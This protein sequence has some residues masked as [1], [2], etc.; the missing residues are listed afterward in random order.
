MK[1]EFGLNQ[2][3]R[4]IGLPR[5][6]WYYHQ[7][8]KVDYDQKYWQ[9]KQDLLEITREH[10]S[11]GY[12]RIT[13]ELNEN[14][15][16]HINKKVV[17]KLTRNHELQLIRKV[18]KPKPSFITKTLVALRDKMNIVGLMLAE[19]KTISLFEVCYT[20]FTELIYGCGKRRAQL[21]P[22]IEHVSKI[23]LGWAVGNTP[24]TK[25]AL[26]AWN[27]AAKRTKGLG[28]STE[29]LIAHHDRDPV[30]TG[31]E[32]LDQLLLVDKALVSYALRGFKDNPEMESFNGHF[33]GENRDL[34]WECQTLEEL[35]RVVSEQMVYYN[36]KR[37]HSSIGNIAP[38]AYLKNWQKHRRF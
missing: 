33:K 10:A 3:L 4:I 36:T 11:Y 9:V 25:V 20:D 28:F 16:H 8:C 21:M 30:Y 7:K 5:N 35:K 13:P 1:D 23:S 26:E 27:M 14:Y 34:F 19:G 29:R 37:R 24:N 2:T 17:L 38:L 22:I 31:Y 18:K 12:K 15:G 32:W 6:T